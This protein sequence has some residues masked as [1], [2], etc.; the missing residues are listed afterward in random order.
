MKRQR[1]D[2]TAS[3]SP[4]RE[5]LEHTATILLD[6]GMSKQSLL[7]ELG[8]VL[9]SRADASHPFDPAGLREVSGYAHVLAHW[10]ADPDYRDPRSTRTPA[11]L[12]LNGQRRSVA[13][14]IRRVFPKE[15]VHA[16]ANA[17]I[18]LGAIKRRGRRYI[19]NAQF[20]LYSKDPAVAHTHAYMALLGHMRTIAYNLACKD[21]T[22]LLFERA[23]TNARV[24]V[25]ALPTIHRHVRRVFADALLRIDAY[26]SR[27]ETQSGRQPTTLIGA[28]AFAFDDSNIA[29]RATRSRELQ[30]TRAKRGA[31]HRRAERT[32]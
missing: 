2:R 20:V 4:A 17:L 10:Y 31:R 8:S 6:I 13:A 16:T 30:R 11:P 22:R 27:W 24:P 32:P 9:Q 1:V 5:I 3:T 26:F 25:S 15:R 18:A 12:P 14:L 19:P 23:A 7:D 21:E 29:A 28:A